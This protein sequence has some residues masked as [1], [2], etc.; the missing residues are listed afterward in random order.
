VSPLSYRWRRRRRRA[1]RLL[2]SA[3]AWI[4]AAGAIAGA[5]TAVLLLVFLVFPDW[6]PCFGETTADFEDV[7]ATQLGS[8]L[9][10][11]SYTVVTHGYEGKGLR[12]VW[13]LR[14]R[15]TGGSYVQVPGLSRQPVGTLEPASCSAD[16]G[17]DDLTVPLLEHGSYQVV[18]ELF[19]PGQHAARVARVEQEFSL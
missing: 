11:V 9:E 15:D 13:S 3:K 4:I 16:Q 5:A 10:Q 7:E 12:I 19:P 17:G 18:L 1:R 2:G 6:K 14:K 8:L